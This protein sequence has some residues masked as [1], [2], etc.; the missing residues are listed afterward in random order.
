MKALRPRVA[1]LFATLAFGAATNVAY[2][3]DCG[4]DCQDKCKRFGVRNPPCEIACE[5]EKTAMGCYQVTPPSLP[6]ANCAAIAYS[7]ST[8]R[9]GN[10]KDLVSTTS[11]GNRALIYCNAAVT[12]DCSVVVSGCNTCLA[13]HVGSGRGYGYAKNS[14]RY[15]AE[16]N[17]Y[18]SCTKYTRG[19]KL[20]T[21][22][23]SGPR[24]GTLLDEGMSEQDETGESSD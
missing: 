20:A 5:G 3:T 14:E 2:G 1:L 6:T 12:N 18:M 7:R 10:A 19:C 4:T 8:G 22:V 21:S 15:L 23:C 13:L 16:S 11:A 9:W 24:W 17:A